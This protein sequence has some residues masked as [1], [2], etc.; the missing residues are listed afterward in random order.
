MIPGRNRRNQIVLR[1]DEIYKNTLSLKLGE[2]D[3]II[4]FE[5][6]ANKCIEASLAFDTEV[7]KQLGPEEES[8]YNNE[9]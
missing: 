6:I 5:N 4:D 2:N 3:H 8:S 9:D 7:I 1:A